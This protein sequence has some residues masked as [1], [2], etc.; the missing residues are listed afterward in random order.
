MAKITYL[1]EADDNDSVVVDGI[2]FAAYQ[3][4]DIDPTLKNDLIVKLAKNP[5]FARGELDDEQQLRQ[6]HWTK[7]RKAQADA[8]AHR[9]HAD[10]LEKNPGG[11]APDVLADAHKQ[12]A[13]IVAGAQAQA[14]SLLAAAQAQA[15]AVV[16]DAQTKADG[17]VAQAKL[18]ANSIVSA[19]KAAPVD[20]PQPVVTSAPVADKPN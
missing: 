12:A 13:E 7:V 9:E 18:D 17:L 19:A 11:A 16:A 10:A 2:T 20:A 8:K 1:P 3:S 15:E 6:A 4:V 5:W 14:A